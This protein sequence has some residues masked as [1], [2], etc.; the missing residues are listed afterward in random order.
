MSYAN[1]RI[2]ASAQADIHEQLERRVR[3]HLAEPFRKPFADYNRHALDAALAGWDRRAP[4]ILDAGC[5]VGHSTIQLARAYP[6]HWVIGVDQSEDRLVRRKPYPDALLPR[7]M[8]FVRADLV[9]FWRL[10]HAANLRLARHYILYPNPWPKIGHLGRR[11][12]AHPVFPFVPLLGGVLESRTNW[13]VYAEELAFA[14]GVVLGR[15]VACEP[16]EAVVPLT[17]FERKYRDS[18][19]AL[20]RVVCE[21][22]DHACESV[23]EGA[24]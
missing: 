12:H 7:N 1:S 6:D 5:G 21:L 15:E 17:P 14:L 24:R 19:Q 9:D 4:L 16:Y 22:G 13:R 18:G 3:R 23:P 8:V 11:W 10:L 20:Y 2:P